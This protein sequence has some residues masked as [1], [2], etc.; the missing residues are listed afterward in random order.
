MV[1]VRYVILI[2][3]WH[4]KSG[5]VNAVR[6]KGETDYCS[7][8]NLIMTFYALK[9]TPLPHKEPMY[10]RYLQSQRKSLNKSWNFDYY[11]CNNLLRYIQYT[12]HYKMN[13]IQQL[14]QSNVAIG[15]GILR[16]FAKINS[17][18]GLLNKIFRWK[19]NLLKRNYNYSNA[20]KSLQMF[21]TLYNICKKRKTQSKHPVGVCNSRFITNISR[22]LI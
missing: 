22:K 21:N 15:Y 19:T 20:D 1:I 2:P 12:A 8:R 16:T 5:C 17:S 10:L 11:V 14:L 4:R 18:T 6:L 13:H 7:L 9:Y 3:I